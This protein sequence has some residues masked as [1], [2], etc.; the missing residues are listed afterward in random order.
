MESK[1]SSCE[2]ARN[3]QSPL[4]SLPSR[5]SDCSASTSK[6]SI[7]RSN[8]TE[9]QLGSHPSM[10]APASRGNKEHKRRRPVSVD[11]SDSQSKTAGISASRRTYNTADIP[12][13]PPLLGT[14]SLGGYSQLVLAKASYEPSK[15]PGRVD[16]R[17]DL[18]SSGKAQ[19][20]MASVEIQEHSAIK[21]A[22]RKSFLFNRIEFDAR[23]SPAKFHHSSLSF[24]HHL[25]PPSR[26]SGNQVIV[27][28]WAVAVDALDSMIVEKLSQKVKNVGFVPGR[29]FVGRVVET[30]YTV[31][32]LSLGDWTFG[33]M[34]VQK[35]KNHYTKQPAD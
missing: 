9:V 14:S 29:S 1:Q 10:M 16:G 34:D 5:H 17:V 3:K 7:Y 35:V 21:L 33:L 15:N 6:S 4:T 11:I 19:T 18:I 22:N 20:T 2:A 31:S 13:P 12:D 26:I 24:M 23:H 32:S 30:G 25:S 8:P 28:V 27:Q